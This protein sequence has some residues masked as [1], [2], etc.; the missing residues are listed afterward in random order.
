MQY[1]QDY[2]ERYVSVY[3][4]AM[5]YPAGRIIWADKLQPY[6]KNRHVFVCPSNSNAS[7]APYTAVTVIP[8]SLQ[9]VRYGM[10]MVHV[11]PEGWNSPASMASFEAP[12]ETVAIIESSNGWFTHY[13]PRHAVGSLQTDA[14]G[15]TYIQGTYTTVWPMHMDGL[16]VAFCDG[17]VKWEKITNLSNSNR[18][19][20]WDRN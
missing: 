8:D 6:I 7:D 10:P 18:R 12:S 4:D 16:N 17:H 15:N 1:C 5:G 2:D 19:Y 3:D 14:N 13:C 9:R 11:F 20:L